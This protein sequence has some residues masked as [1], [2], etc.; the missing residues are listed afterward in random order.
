MRAEPLSTRDYDH[1]ESARWDA[2]RQELLW[3]DIGAGRFLRAPLDE[4]HAPVVHEAGTTV[5]AV[6]PCAAGGWLL[7]AG[8]GI[9]H[10]A[11]DG[12]QQVLAELEPAGVRMNDATCDPQGRFWAGSMAFDQTP[13]AASLHRL[14]LDGSVRPVLRGLTIS[15]GLGWSPS[16]D[17]LYLNDS[18][19][20]TTW[21]FD[22]D[23]ETG[24]L[25]RQRPLISHDDGACDGMAVDDEGC[26]WIPLWG[27]SAV[28][29]FDPQGR[30][31]QRVELAASQPSD[32]CLVGGRLVIT[33]AR[34]EL[35]EPTPA[36]GLLY[37]ADVGV[38]GPPVTAY[39][40]ALPSAAAASTASR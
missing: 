14:D 20:S 30:R 40:G 8:R 1:G 33:T 16:H 23:P 11:E 21:A 25:S 12:G 6:T 7:A 15:N 19:P 22:V 28:D 38:T 10:V 29:R 32:C 37:V 26:L 39:A 27:G 35:W 3:V 5:G 17:V 13:G 36:D 24:A 4:V 31:M 9:V 34:H 18:G 2:Q